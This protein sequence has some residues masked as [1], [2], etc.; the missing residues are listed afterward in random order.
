MRLPKLLGLPDT[1]DPDDRRRRQILNIIL[2][3][4]IAGGLISIIATSRR[5]RRFGKDVADESVGQHE[6]RYDQR[7]YKGLII[8]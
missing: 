7:E 3:L 8:G 5:L 2:A 4:F 1:F 6:P